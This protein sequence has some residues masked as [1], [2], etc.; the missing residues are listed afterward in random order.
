MMNLQFRWG[1]AIIDG[2]AIG[3]YVCGVLLGIG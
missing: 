3:V 2:K 1:R